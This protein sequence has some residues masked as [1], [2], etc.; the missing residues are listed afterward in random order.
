MSLN[1]FS[2]RARNSV[3]TPIRLIDRSQ[4]APQ[5]L[6]VNIAPTTERP[7]E[8]DAER[9]AAMQRMKNTLLQN[10]SP[11][12]GSSV[13]RRGTR[14]G[15]RGSRQSTLGLAPLSTSP[16]DE[17]PLQS[18][19]DAHRQGPQQQERETAPLS[20]TPSS[21]N[22][23]FMIAS[24]NAPPVPSIPTP[25]RA[26]SILS[27]SSSQQQMSGV[28]SSFASA[29][30]GASGFRAAILETVNVLFRNGQRERV[31]VTGSVA[32]SLNIPVDG[33]LKIRIANYERFDKS[34][35]NKAFLHA[36]STPGEFTVD[37]QALQ[38]SNTPV[39]T[40]LKYQVKTD[41]LNARAFVPVEVYAQ[42]KLEPNQTSFLMTYHGNPECQFASADPSPFGEVSSEAVPRL[43]DVAF[44][45]PVIGEDVSNVQSKPAGTYSLEKHR[46]LW[47]MDDLDMS[48]SRAAKILARWQVGSTAQPQPVSVQW[49]LPN[50]LA[51]QTDLQVVGNED[52]K[53][54]EI[55]KSTS[56][57]KYQ[58][59]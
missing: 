47:K 30:T 43:Q 19:V 37:A 56:S 25:V 2:G 20:A 4:I 21:P 10:K 34:A 53:L 38:N 44:S 46:I 18:I 35:P 55:I 58:A 33:P 54:D 45:V 32:L 39:T 40:V 9:E 1:P 42:W 24:P 36:T 22:G 28:T 6:R 16:G 15:G 12:I 11:T 17:V 8:T 27:T 5:N 29:K 49:R 26:G 48:T 52:V 50:R 41:N 59:H 14:A 31:L 51:S 23:S 13:G 3:L 7:G 57:G